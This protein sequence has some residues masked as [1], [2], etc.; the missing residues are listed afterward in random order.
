MLLI[1]LLT[2]NGLAGE[3]SADV[4]KP[5]PPVEEIVSKTNLVSYYQGADGRARVAMVITDAQGRE[6]SREFTILRWDDPGPGTPTEGK[7][8]EQYE[9]DQKFYVYFQRPADVN[10]MVFMVWKHLHGDDDRWLY[11]PAL[12]LVKRIAAKDKRT[13]F[14]GSHFLYEDVSGRHVDADQHE[15]VETTENYFVLKNIPRDADAVEFSYYKMWIHRETYLVVQSVYYDKQ[16]NEYRTYKAL[17]VKNIQGYP[18]VTKSRMT[19]DKMGG[20]TEMSYT[21][22][23]YNIGVPEDVFAE[24]YLRRAPYK[25]LR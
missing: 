20:F 15:L 16:G 7:K 10:K 12:D 13:S 21:D 11:M 22:V 25:Y 17:E 19:D 24:R 4:S 23:E 1:G 8:D 2:G 3:Q 5:A 6:R 9:G 14:V 18:T